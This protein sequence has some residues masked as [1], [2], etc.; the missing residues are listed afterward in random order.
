MAL[1]IDNVVTSGLFKLD[2]GEWN[3]DNNVWI[4]GD[5]SEV[6]IIDAAHDAEAIAKAVGNR[7][8]KG[9][10]ATHGHSDHV[11]AAPKLSSLVDAPVYLHPGDDMLW[12]AENP[13]FDF[14]PI[15]DG[16]IFNV[17]GADLKVLNTPGHSPGSIV[18]YA[19]EAGELFSGDTLFQGGPG[20]TGRSYSS[21]DTIIE[22]LQKRVL[23]LPAETIVRTGHG[24]HTTVG[25]EAPHLEEWIKR[26]Y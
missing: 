9:I 15:S 22:S 26:G 24:E 16:D 7:T 20:A 5:D 19:E 13:D 3:V 18:L 23:D 21:F 12:R 6:F 17:A 10:I 25:A 4:V 1:Q 8:V 2:G 11:D 14:E